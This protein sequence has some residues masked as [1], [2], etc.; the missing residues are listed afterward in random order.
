L[1]D[2][3]AGLAVAK[4]INQGFALGMQLRIISIAG[5]QAVAM[6]YGTGAHAVGLLIVRYDGVLDYAVVFDATS[7][8]GMAQQD[9][10]HNGAVEVVRT[11]SPY[12]GSFVASPYISSYDTGRI[13]RL[14]VGDPVQVWANES[15]ARHT[16]VTE[17]NY[18]PTQLGAGISGG[19]VLTDQQST[20][21]ETLTGPSGKEF[22]LA[23]ESVPPLERALANR[24]VTRAY[25]SDII[26]TVQARY[27]AEVFPTQLVQALGEALRS[28][29]VSWLREYAYGGMLATLQGLEDG[30]GSNGG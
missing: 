13:A 4:S 20:D 27:P 15:P 6:E 14:A 17:Y 7:D 23:S 24:E 3:P 29:P 9:L 25:L 5:R 8:A 22:S 1:Q 18:S 2:A 12:G 30:D 16:G 10:S 26:T 21:F 28:L 19:S 11:G